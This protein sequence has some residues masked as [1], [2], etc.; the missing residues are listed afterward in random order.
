M[1]QILPARHTLPGCTLDRNCQMQLPFHSAGSGGQPSYSAAPCTPACPR[2]STVLPAAAGSQKSPQAGIHLHR[3]PSHNHVFPE[4][5]CSPDSFYINHFQNL[6]E[7]DN[8]TKSRICPH[9]T[10]SHYHPSD[11]PPIRTF[12]SSFFT[13][14]F[15]Y[16]SI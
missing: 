15:Y 1:S 16:T 10:I 12:F 7:S 13:C 6:Q 14:L 4:I 2:E 3:V 11:F 9:Q 5:P 8:D